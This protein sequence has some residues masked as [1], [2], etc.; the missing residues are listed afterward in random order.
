MAKA[1]PVAT[2]FSPAGPK[3]PPAGEIR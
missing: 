3:E 2:F 1:A